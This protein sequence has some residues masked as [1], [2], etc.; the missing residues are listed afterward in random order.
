MIPSSLKKAV[1]VPL[2]K[3]SSLNQEVLKHFRPVSNLSYLSKV[4]ERVVAK[5]IRDHMDLNNLHELLQSAYKKFHSCETALLKVK[6][7]ILRAIDDKKC[8]L[9]VL[10]DLSAAFDTV[11]HQKLIEILAEKFGLA[12]TAL[13]WFRD[14]LTERI[15]SVLID[16]VESDIWNILFGVPQGSVLGPYLFIIYTSPLGEILRRHGILFHLY[17]DDT[18]LYLSFTVDEI[19][20]AILKMEECIIEIRTW[21]ASNFLRLNDEKTEFLVIGSKHHLSKISDSFLAVGNDSIKSTPSARNIGVLFDKNLCM[22]NHVSQICKGAWNHL[23]LLG[24]IRPYLDSKSASTLMHSYVSSRL[25]SFN[26]LLY[27]LPKQEIDRI[28][29]VQNAA[30][31]VVSLTKK[32]DHITPVL[33]DLHWLPIKERIKFKISLLTFKSLNEM[34]PA[35]LRDLLKVSKKDRSLRSNNKCMLVVPKTKTVKYGDSSFSYAAPVLW[36]QLPEDCRME[37]DLNSFK[38]KLKTFLFKQ[39]F[40]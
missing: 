8:V 32:F 7:D 14:Y 18:Q 6:D 17:A 40:N 31:R 38:S 20:S 21:M 19:D 12:G 13:K 33:R 15:Q 1:V 27:G 29:R 3:K 22:D 16:G 23:R 5:R 28:Q 34:A 11:D 25:D 26:S 9:L 2:L 35:Y 4:I 10:L 36:N 39:A 24:K 30:A 37:T